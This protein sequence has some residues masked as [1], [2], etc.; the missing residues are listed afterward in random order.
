MSYKE[1]LKPEVARNVVRERVAVLRRIYIGAV[2]LLSEAE[3]WE[4]QT[5]AFEILRWLE[6]AMACNNLNPP[7]LPPRFQLVLAG[8]DLGRPGNLL[9]RAALG[10]AHFL[11]WPVFPCRPGSEEPLEPS[12]LTGASTDPKQIEAWWQ[13]WPDA[14]IGVPTGAP[15]KMVALAVD[16]RQGGLRSL[17]QLE[18]DWG[19]IPAEIMSVFSFSSD[20]LF[21]LLY[22]DD[23]YLQSGNLRSYPGL[24]LRANGDYVLVPPSRF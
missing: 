11:G 3:P 10:Y 7:E 8:R 21:L 19:P 13:Q 5:A 16:C 2:A 1:L 23:L 24:S 22:S 18:R 17:T 12:G 14:N 4:D 15:S 20:R 9:L 6:F